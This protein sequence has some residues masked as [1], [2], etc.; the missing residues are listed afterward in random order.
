MDNYL[1]AAFPAQTENESLSRM[2]AA[3]FVTDAN[4]TVSE[5]ADI[6]TAV[7]EAV[8]NA[9][10]HGY[11][12]MG[13]TVTMELFREGRRITIKVSDQG[14]GIDNVEKAREPFYT[15]APEEERSGMGFSVMESFM[16]EV[17]IDSCPGRGTQ[18]TLVKT[19]SE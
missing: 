4:P 16:D 7:S 1:K 3:A 12:R 11:R 14:V 6:K 15:T 17:Q 2:I 13:G 10:I 19:L 8:T 9:I 18:V 5:L